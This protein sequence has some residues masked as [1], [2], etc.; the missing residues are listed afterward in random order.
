M[1][2]ATWFRC[3][4]R[5]ILCEAK[6]RSHLYS[7][8]G[9]KWSA[10][11]IT[12][13]ASEAQLT[14]LLRYRPVIHA[15]S[16]RATSTA[17]GVTLTVSFHTFIP[18]DVQSASRLLDQWRQSVSEPATSTGRTGCQPGS[19]RLPVYISDT[20]NVATWRL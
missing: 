13:K 17:A 5:P 18:R 16:C 10:N 3:S 4:L 1:F 6:S 15:G 2:A 9:H 12:T 19:R 8:F 7:E 11:M 14:Y 20:P